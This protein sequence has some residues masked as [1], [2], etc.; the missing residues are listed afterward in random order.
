[1]KR[2]IGILMLLVGIGIIGMNL[3][4]A[5]CDDPVKCWNP[6]PSPSGHGEL[7][8]NCNS[9]GSGEGCWFSWMCGYFTGYDCRS[10][11]ETEIYEC[12]GLTDRCNTADAGKEYSAVN[13]QPKSCIQCVGNFIVDDTCPHTHGKAS[14]SYY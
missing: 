1:M 2:I 5:S 9:M 12:T 13:G 8:F 7:C 11:G 6:K 14:W 10:T 3:V 4:S